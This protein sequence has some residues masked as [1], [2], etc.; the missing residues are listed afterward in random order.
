MKIE[1]LSITQN[2]EKLCERSART[3]YDSGSK[4]TD[5][6]YQKMLAALLRSGHLSVFEHASASF[7]IEGISRSASHQIVRHRHSSF[8]QRSQRYVN[9][10]GFDFV[11]PTAVSANPE[12]ETIYNQSIQ[13]I[14][15]AY[16]KLIELGIKK[17]DARFLMP[18]AA[19]TTLAMTANFREWLHIIDMRVAK[20]AQW[21]IRDLCALIWK[22]LY[23]QA[24]LIFSMVYFENWSKDAAYKQE[25]F[26]ERIV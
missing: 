25:I 15:E 21:E 19:S 13:Q 17:E 10:N 11:T 24:P 16:D 20:G 23:Q 18:N 9:E 5:D 6:S 8:S 12:A 2:A 3:C 7:M 14:Q 22:R 26:N 1:L 4:T